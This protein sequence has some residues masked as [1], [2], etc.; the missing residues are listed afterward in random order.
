MLSLSWKEWSCI[1][2]IYDLIYAHFEDDVAFWLQKHNSS[3]KDIFCEFFSSFPA[4]FCF[5]I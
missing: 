4:T 1:F 5:Q 3:Y 2:Q